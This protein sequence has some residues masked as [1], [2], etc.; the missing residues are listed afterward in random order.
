MPAKNTTPQNYETFDELWA[1]IST[2]PACRVGVMADG[3]AHLYRLD[4]HPPF[5]MQ[6][7]V[8]KIYGVEPKK[9]NEARKRNPA[10]F[11]EGTDYFQLDRREV[12]KCDLAYSGGHLPY[13][14]TKRGAYMFATILQTPE[15]TEQAIRIVEG[16]MNFDRLLEEQ[17]KPVPAPQPIIQAPK[18]EIDAADFWKMKAELAE[19]KLEKAETTKRQRKNFTEAEQTIILA[20][21]ARGKTPAQIAKEI[22]RN[23]NSVESYLRRRR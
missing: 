3:G 17:A 8:A 15:A 23:R 14:Y 6:F 19:L 22:G 2:P 11:K 7:D 5:M 16:F 13:A 9:L 1:Q 10:K 18:V 20:M 4:G 12:A 21:N